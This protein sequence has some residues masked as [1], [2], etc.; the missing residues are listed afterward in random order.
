MS[1]EIIL[2]ISLVIINCSVLLWYKLFGLKGL[3]CFNIFATICA[4][5]EVLILVHAFGMDMTLGNILFASTFLITDI[6]SEL[7]SKRESNKIVNMGIGI[8]VL[9]I[10]I[11]QLWLLF[12]P[13]SSDFAFPHIEALFTNTPRLIFASLVVY[14][15]SQKLDVFLYHKLWNFTNN[16]FGDK[17]KYLYVRNNLSTLTSQLVNAVLYNFFAFYG[18]YELGTLMSIVI[19]SYLIFIAT[20]LLDTPIVY[21]A[22]KIKEKNIVAE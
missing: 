13:A 9:F 22:R 16:K 21:L 6:V 1:N 11:S 10:I 2:I 20:S 18:V 4:N 3:Y 14:A 17:R 5:I 7:Y 8:S 19:T 15:I 12:T